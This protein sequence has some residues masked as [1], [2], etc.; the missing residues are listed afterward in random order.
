MAHVWGFILNYMSATMTKELIVITLILFL[1]ACTGKNEEVATKENKEAATIE[2]KETVL[3]EKNFSDLKVLDISAFRF[4]AVSEEMVDKSHQFN[5]I[6]DVYMK[7]EK[8][9][10]TL[11][12]KD[13]F[14]SAKQYSERASVVLAGPYSKEVTLNDML[15]FSLPAQFKYNADNETA[16]IMINGSKKSNDYLSIETKYSQ[17]SPAPKS[18]FF[19][20]I[21][22]RNAKIA[23]HA[24]IS[25]KNYGLMS[26]SMP[27]V[28]WRPE[29]DYSQYMIGNLAKLKIKRS[30]ANVYLNSLRVMIVFKLKPPYL[31]ESTFAAGGTLAESYGL[32]GDAIGLIIYSAQNGAIIK[33]I[34]SR[35]GIDPIG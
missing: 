16:E 28:K 1:A 2:A 20:E 26:K 23:N 33:R 6:S 3:G 12:E 24:I 7:I 30:D 4:Q 29:S 8:H 9:L 13:E 18:L 31:V 34:P 32:Y 15:A 21:P 14:E 17:I 19:I 10:T 25:V 5:V 27:F 35:F 11:K 22:D